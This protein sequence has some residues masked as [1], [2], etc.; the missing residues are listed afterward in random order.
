[1]SDAPVTVKLAEIHL[2]LDPDLTSYYMAITPE[3]ARAFP[4]ETAQ[5]ID[6]LQH[7]G[8]LVPPQRVYPS[9]ELKTDG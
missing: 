3:T 5:L 4:A 2:V 9:G 8:A 6:A 1:M 7:D